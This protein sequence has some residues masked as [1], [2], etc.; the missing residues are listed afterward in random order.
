MPTRKATKASPAKQTRTPAPVLSPLTFEQA[1]EGL[2]KTPVKQL[3]AKLAAEK[4]A[5]KS[6]K[7]GN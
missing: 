4:A 5:K 3:R 6:K 1:V 2:L 7:P